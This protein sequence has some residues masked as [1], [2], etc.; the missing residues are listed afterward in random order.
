M[1]R[2]VEGRICSFCGEP[3]SAKRRLAG[4]LGA[5]ICFEC[6]ESYYED[7]RSPERVEAGTR[8]VWDEM[9]DTELLA[10]LPLIVR[11]AEQN[12]AF[13]RD[14]VALIRERKVSWAQIGKVLGVSRQAAW[15]RFAS[16][17]RSRTSASG[18]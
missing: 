3:G 9:T 15:E 11:S 17:A 8:S 6:L 1:D 13:V 18:G 10:Q 5:M 16:H 12:A 7:T 2:H 14:W 4:G